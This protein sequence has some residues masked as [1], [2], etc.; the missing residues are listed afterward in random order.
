MPLR[1]DPRH[2]VGISHRSHLEGRLD[3]AKVE[4][5]DALWAKTKLTIWIKQKKIRLKCNPRCRYEFADSLSELKK[6]LT[7]TIYGDIVNA[8]EDTVNLEIIKGGQ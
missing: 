1:K 5:V 6:K 4:S 7:G 2:Y 3:V 8:I